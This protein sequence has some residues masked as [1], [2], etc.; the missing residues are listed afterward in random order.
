M[1]RTKQPEA[2]KVYIVRTGEDAKAYLDNGDMNHTTAILDNFSI[3]YTLETVD[4][5]SASH[6]KPKGKGGR[7]RKES[8]N[9][10]D[11]ATAARSRHA[12]SCPALDPL[13][14][15]PCNCGFAK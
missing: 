1:P 12:I 6:A 3:P 15:V 14:E 7:P 4:L 5:A 11:A 10:G 9:G 8:P 13:S 2:E